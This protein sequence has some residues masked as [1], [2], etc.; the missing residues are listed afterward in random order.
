MS[1]SSGTHVI[2]VLGNKPLEDDS[3]DREYKDRCDWALSVARHEAYES[4]KGSSCVIVLTGG[5][6]VAG[7]PTES[8]VASVYLEEKIEP[9]TFEKPLVLLEQKSRT[10]PE[11]IVYT[12]ELLRERGI[13]PTKL[14]VIGRKSQILKTCIIVSRIWDLGNPRVNF[15]AGIDTT[16]FWYQCLD[17]TLMCLISALDPYDRWILSIFKKISRN[18]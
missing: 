14:T 11:N 9:F 16:P 12:L 3:L 15:I 17:Q 2:I 18:G 5:S 6:T 4:Y 13:V 1:K 10:T 8:E 7:K